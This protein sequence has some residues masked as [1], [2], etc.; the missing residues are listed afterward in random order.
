MLSN[1]LSLLLSVDEG[2]NLL[3]ENDYQYKQIA[4]LLRFKQ[5]KLSILMTKNNIKQYYLFENGDRYTRAS[6]PL[7]R[8]TP[9]SQLSSN[10]DSFRINRR[11][12]ESGLED[13]FDQ[14]PRPTR[15]MHISMRQDI[16]DVKLTRENVKLTGRIHWLTFYR[17]LIRQLH[18]IIFLLVIIICINWPIRTM[19]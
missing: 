19:F 14:I 5:N 18:Y 7:K 12:T 17:H 10:N 8:D 6:I 2:N 3:S 15:S 4:K 13:I 1:S 9:M 16:S 11:R